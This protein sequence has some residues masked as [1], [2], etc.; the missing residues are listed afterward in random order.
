[1]NEWRLERRNGGWKDRLAEIWMT[2]RLTHPCISGQFGVY[3]YLR[4]WALSLV[5]C[6]QPCEAGGLSSVLQRSRLMLAK[7]YKLST[8]TRSKSTPLTTAQLPLPLKFTIH[9]S[10]KRSSPS[11]STPAC[12][13]QATGFSDV[14]H[15]LLFKN[16]KGLLSRVTFW[17]TW[18]HGAMRSHSPGIKC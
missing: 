6:K 15:G 5:G 1:M 7:L 12:M 13:V 17:D 4:L 9:A 14:S 8:V 3:E 11:C 10:N 18:S 2:Q 16:P